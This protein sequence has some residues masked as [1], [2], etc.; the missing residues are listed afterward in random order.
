MKHFFALSLACVAMAAQLESSATVWRVNNQGYSADY[1]GSAALQDAIADPF[2]SPNGTRDTIHL[3][4]SPVSYGS[5]TL[6]K[7]I[8]IIGPGYKLGQGAANNYG[9]QANNQMATVNAIN[10]NGG[11]DGTIISGIRFAGGGGGLFINDASQI[12]ATRN[13]FDGP[14]IGFTDYTESDITIT[15]NYFNAQNA[16]V[17][18]G[19]ALP[20]IYS[21]VVI[22]NNYIGGYIGFDPTFSAV[23]ITNN[24]LNWN[25]THSPYGAD[26]KNNILV[27]GSVAVN[28]NNIH[29]NIAASATGLPTG[30]NTY[31]VNSVVMNSQFVTGGSDDAKWHLH[32]TSTYNTWADDGGELGMYGGNTPYVLSGIPAIPAIYGL[33]TAATAIQGQPLPVT[34]STRSND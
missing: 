19:N 5:V 9:L 23:S 27:L 26:F 6:T 18:L 15:C 28:D 24:V 16:I 11:A 33:S 3:E 17:T 20:G 29:H 1:T 4:A 12:T 2:V 21:N 10:L 8:V 7:P 32:P 22:A 34:I 30:P 14:G 25:A 31:N 13:F